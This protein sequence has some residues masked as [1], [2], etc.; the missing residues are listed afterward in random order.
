MADSKLTIDAPRP[1]RPPL[2]VNVF[3]AMQH[4]NTQL[5][6]LFPYVHPGAVVPA[7]AILKGGPDADYGHFFHHNTQDEVVVTLAA[8]GCV[9]A[10]GQVFVG[11]RIHGV[12]SFLKNEKDPTGYSVQMITQLQ[13]ESGPQK[14]ACSMRCEKCHEEI[15]IREFDATPHP[16]G[17]ETDIPFPSITV[18][19]EIFREFNADEK[20]RTCVKCGHVTRPF[21]LAAW[22]WEKYEGQSTTIARGKTDLIAA[23]APPAK[24]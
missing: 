11:S 12:N 5:M 24:A 15:F 22:G 21:P 19:A 6:P 18:S 7:G 16:D 10:T 9:L 14:E 2:K 1:D 23:A 8:K 17:N 13:V 20:L 4:G 3:A